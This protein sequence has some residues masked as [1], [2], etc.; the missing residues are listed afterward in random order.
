MPRIDVVVIGAG[1]IGAS[2]AWHLARAGRRVMVLEKEPGPALHQSG[3]NSGVVHAG[4]NVKPGTAKARFCLEGNRQLRAYCAE[5]GIPLEVGGILVVARTEPERAVLAELH[6]RATGNGVDV[7]M[8]D[9]EGIRAA[10]PHAVGIEALQA[11]EAGSFDARAD[12]HAPAGDAARPGAMLAFGREAYS[13]WSLRG[14]KL[15]RT[16]GWGGFWRM[17]MRREFRRLIR[18]EVGKSL[19]LRAIWKEARL[20]V[21]ELQ[22]EDLV[23]SYAGN[24]AQMV[25]RK[26]QL[27]EDMVVRETP[28]AVHVLNAVSPG[29]TCSLPFGEHLAGLAGKKLDP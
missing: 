29:L 17:M 20:L 6:Q 10:E 12:V 11:R 2:A 25:D 16:L 28:R 15:G 24:R 5:R 1:A 4:Y 18:D 22:P 21:P 3:R 7:R 13:L 8:L 26:G 19:S 14:G 23:R 9:A 27:V